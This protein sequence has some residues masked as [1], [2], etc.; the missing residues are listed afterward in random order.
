MK[1]QKRTLRPSSE[2]RTER[3]SLF[4][5]PV[6]SFSASGNTANKGQGGALQNQIY[7]CSLP[8]ATHSLFSLFCLFQPA[9]PTAGTAAHRTMVF[10]NNVG[11]RV[12]E[13]REACADSHEQR[14]LPG[15]GCL[16]ESTWSTCLECRW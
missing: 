8:P 5:Q 1:I 10:T 4:V 12:T 7:V 9:T 15:T 16:S 11:N 13:I 14:F 3:F 6:C 2:R